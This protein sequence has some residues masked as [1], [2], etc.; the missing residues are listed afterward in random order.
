MF[1]GMKREGD[2]FFFQKP[3][4]SLSSF[5]FLL[6]NE[7]NP[8]HGDHDDG[9]NGRTIKIDELASKRM[10]KGTKIPRG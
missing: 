7:Q 3:S 6:F 2:D 1:M 5:F 9:A 4:S 8:N 10:V